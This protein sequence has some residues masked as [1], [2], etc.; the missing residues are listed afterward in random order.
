MPPIRFEEIYHPDKDHD[1][2]YRKAAAIEILG[3]EW[4]HISVGLYLSAQMV[5]RQSVIRQSP[6]SPNR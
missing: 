3:E 4:F 2:R 5:F 1:R 6:D